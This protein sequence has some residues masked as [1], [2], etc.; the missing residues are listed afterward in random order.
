[1]NEILDKHVINDGLYIYKLKISTRWF[2]RFKIAEKWMARTTKKRDRDE[3]IQEAYRIKAECD[4]LSKHG[5]AIQ[6][7]RSRT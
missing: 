1:M 6:T 3:A 2:A 5:I 4:I 7:S